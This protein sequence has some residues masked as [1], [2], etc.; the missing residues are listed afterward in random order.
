MHTFLIVV[1]FSHWTGNTCNIII[2]GFLLSLTLYIST[3]LIL[4]AYTKFAMH[5]EISPSLGV[6]DYLNSYTC[7]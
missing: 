6:N 5:K 7:T 2:Y 1:R 3:D 4:S